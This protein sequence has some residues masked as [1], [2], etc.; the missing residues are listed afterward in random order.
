MN[1]EFLARI[2]FVVA[3]ALTT[4]WVAVLGGYLRHLGWSGLITLTPMELATV[5]AAAGGPP[6]VLWLSDALGDDRVALEILEEGAMGRAYRL[7]KSA[8]ELA[9]TDNDAGPA[10]VTPKA[11]LFDD[12]ADETAG[13]GR[14]LEAVASPRL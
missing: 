11:D 1:R 5:L 7:F 4:A 8:D 13:L 6:A 2:P 12:T 10:P 14:R 3:V 9:A